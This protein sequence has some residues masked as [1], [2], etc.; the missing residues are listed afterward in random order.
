[1]H[2]A[3]GLMDVSCWQWE[4]AQSAHGP[5][6][7]GVQSIQQGSD[8]TAPE[9]LECQALPTVDRA[10]TA[11][12]SAVSNATSTCGGPETRSPRLVRR[13]NPKGRCA[14][15]S[16]AW[17]RQGRVLAVSLLKALQQHLAGAL[18]A[19]VLEVVIGMLRSRCASPTTLSI[20]R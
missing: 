12:G 1:M 5:R 6:N 7:T 8:A 11:N 20:L 10:A 18:V 13:W 16:S 19:E 14:A 17:R 15:W 9:R 3:C 4:T 2:A